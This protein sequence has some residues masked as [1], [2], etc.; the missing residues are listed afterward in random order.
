M[1]LSGDPSMDYREKAAQ[2]K[3][4]T[5]VVE[6]GLFPDFCEKIIVGGPDAVRVAEN[7]KRGHL[8]I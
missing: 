5:G 1:D 6:I 8:M 2:L 7:N 4:L 3:S